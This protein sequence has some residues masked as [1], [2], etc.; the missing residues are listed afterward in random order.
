MIGVVIGVMSQLRYL[1]A[2]VLGAIFG[3][4]ALDL[5]LDLGSERFLSCSSGD[6]NYWYNMQRFYDSRPRIEMFGL[7]VWRFP[8]IASSQDIENINSYPNVNPARERGLNPCRFCS[9]SDN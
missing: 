2:T 5:I 6:M 3:R 1:L 8:L 9:G 7:L 4:W